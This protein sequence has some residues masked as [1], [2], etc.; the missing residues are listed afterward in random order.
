MDGETDSLSTSQK[1]QNRLLR[2][3]K[4][5][6]TLEN[7]NEELIVQ[8]RSLNEKLNLSRQ[9]LFKSVSSQTDLSYCDRIT[10]RENDFDPRLSKENGSQNQNLIESEQNRYY[11]DFE[12]KIYFDR[13]IGC[14]IY[15]ESQTLY[16][17]SN[18]SYYRYNARSKKYEFLCHLKDREKNFED[19]IEEDTEM[20][21]GEIDETV[22]DQGEKKKLLSIGPKSIDSSNDSFQMN[23]SNCGNGSVIESKPILRGHIESRDDEE[24]L[25]KLY[26]HIKPCYLK[27]K[28]STSLELGETLIIT[29]MG[30]KIGQHPNCSVTIP[31]KTVSQ[32]HAEINFDPVRKIYTIQDLVSRNGTIVNGVRLDP[33]KKNPLFNGDIIELADCCKLS[34]NLY[35]TDQEDSNANS[36]NILNEKMHPTNLKTS[37]EITKTLKRKYGLETQKSEK[38][39][40]IIDQDLYRDRALERQQTKGSDCPYEKTAA[41]T[42]LNLPLTE[43]N[44]GFQLL[45]RMGWKCGESLGKNPNV[46]DSVEPIEIETNEEKYG[47][48]YK[49]N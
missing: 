22:I 6:K 40:D 37:K 24:N 29:A 45:K 36:S 26:N 33:L 43:Q 1:L 49:A 25:S 28:S 15:P 34:V 44:K 21:E 38:L 8:I 47:L 10:K 19:K 16:N 41:G 42:A 13:S 23:Q 48:G 4:T 12:N 39:R 11:Y 7:Y 3:E 32:I 31:D 27:V 5:I 46:V 18:Q 20:E 2:A 35:H 9:Y 14:Y 30:G 17:T